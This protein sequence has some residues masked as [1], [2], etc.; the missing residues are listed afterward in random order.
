MTFKGLP[1]SRQCHYAGLHARIAGCSA[2]V[3]S[4]DQPTSKSLKPPTPKQPLHWTECRFPAL[5]PA[6]PRDYYEPV[7]ESRHMAGKRLNTT[8]QGAKRHEKPVH[9]RTRKRGLT[10]LDTPTAQFLAS[11]SLQL[12]MPACK[13]EGWKAVPKPR[14]DS[15]ALHFEMRLPCKFGSSEGLKPALPLT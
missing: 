15:W 2:N 14:S 13:C 5:V 4:T 12:A 11:A 9:I 1:W 3:S 8:R 6:S 10:W 7:L